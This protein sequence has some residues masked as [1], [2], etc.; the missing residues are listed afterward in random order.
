MLP[1]SLVTPAPETFSLGCQGLLVELYS[2]VL[3]IGR[4]LCLEE[5]LF[6]SIHLLYCSQKVPLSSLD[7][8]THMLNLEVAIYSFIFRKGVSRCE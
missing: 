1:Y 2:A 5:M 4:L 6:N 8:P 7:M 3:G